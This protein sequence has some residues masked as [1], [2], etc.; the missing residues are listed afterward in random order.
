MYQIS[1]QSEELCRKQKRRE[2]R[3]TPPLKASYSYFFLEASRDNIMSM[4]LLCLKTILDYFLVY[5]SVY[6]PVSKIIVLVNIICC[7]CFPQ[8]VIF[9]WYCLFSSPSSC[10]FLCFCYCLCS[11]ICPHPCCLTSLL[12]VLY[13]EHFIYREVISSK[14]IQF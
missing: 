14:I 9:A 13:Y 2:A 6:F 5:I 7:F 4:F 12:F 8:F 1:C 3:L 11:C 10:F